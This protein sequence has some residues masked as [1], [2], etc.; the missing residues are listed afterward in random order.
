MDGKRLCCG[1]IGK[2]V[3]SS[4][5]GSLDGPKTQTHRALLTYEPA[6]NTALGAAPT[7]SSYCVCVLVVR[8]NVGLRK[9]CVWVFGEKAVT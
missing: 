2:E 3:G 7:L 1:E 6:N 8:L 4:R 9:M 5:G